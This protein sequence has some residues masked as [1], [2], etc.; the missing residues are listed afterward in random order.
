[1][2]LS[3]PGL[4]MICGLQGSGKSHLIKYIMYQNRKKFNCGIVFTNTG[5]V[6]GNFDYIDKAVI[7]KEYDET[8]L[9]DFKEIFRKHIERDKH[10]HG[11][12]I[13]DDCLTGDQ[14]RSSELLSLITQVR[15]YNI[16]VI[17]SCQY[18][19]TIPPIFRTNAFQVFMFFMGSKAAMKALYESYGQMV[20]TFDEFKHYFMEAT[21]VKHQ[22]L[23]Y[24]A[25]NGGTTIQ[26][27]YK[28]LKCPEK[29]PKFMM[30]TGVPKKL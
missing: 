17:L 18:P 5:F 6:D 29:I 25:R 2:N 23:A 8:V 21:G 26:S 28:L 4:I 27:R 20:G 22:F 24:D 16:T 10:P 3:I 12:V 7:Y 9:R 13:F 15:H 1:M 30:E 19:N 11:F 14:W